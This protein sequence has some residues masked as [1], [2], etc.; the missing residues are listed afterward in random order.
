MP[1]HGPGSRLED[2][3]LMSKDVVLEMPQAFG[4]T[5]KK[6]IYNTVGS[7]SDVL[8]VSNSIVGATPMKAIT[9]TNNE[10]HTIYPILY[11]PN[12]GK[13]TT[14]NYYD[15]ID[16]HN[17][18]YRGYIGYTA[19]GHDYLG[20]QAHHSVTIDVPL[21][22][23]DSGRAALATDPYSLLPK[24]PNTSKASATTN[25][26]FFF[27]YTL[28]GD[29]KMG[30][31]QTSRFVVSADKSTDSDGIVMYYHCGDPGNN[32]V[33]PGADAP[34]QLIEWT[35]RDKKFLTAISQ[36]YGKID[37]DQL[38]DLI[39]Y[40]VSYVDHM[41]LP[42]AMEATNVPIT[43][44]SKTKDYGWVGAD[45]TSAELQKEMLEFT[46]DN[47]K[48]NNENGLGN[49]FGGLGWP[50]FYNP[51]YKPDNEVGIRIPSGASLLLLSPLANRRS[52][53]NNNL[54]MLS[55]GGDKPIEYFYGGKM[56]GQSQGVVTDSEEF[57]AILKR[58]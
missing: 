56:D 3:L 21:V 25:P 24:D 45:I 43:P 16:M 2:R 52:S 55:S 26:F 27:Y 5:E 10:S 53:Y 19:N 38:I 11:D 6:P 39:N 46:K 35:I 32:A 30:T 12:T 54:W 18:E 50:K 57:F 17:Q 40:D 34:D 37:K 48:G 36:N 47:T 8:F 4:S 31:G 33:D 15:P 41:L 28:A 9:I 29:P 22:F 49:Y 13:S 1:I 14:G 23:W 44:T 20:L 7:L 58:G 51:N 42:V